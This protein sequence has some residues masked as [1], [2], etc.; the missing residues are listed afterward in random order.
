M[1]TYEYACTKCGY[2]FEQFQSMKDEPLKKCPQCK[3]PA[4]KRLVGAGAGLIFKGTGFY[5]TDYKKASTPPAGESGGESKPAVS[6]AAPAPAPTA[7]K[8]ATPE[9]KP[10]ASKSSAKKSSAKR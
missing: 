3:K 6:P 7:P 9:K 8:P 2:H 5:I 10:V 1:P 4:L